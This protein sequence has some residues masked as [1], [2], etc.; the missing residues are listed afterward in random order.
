MSKTTRPKTYDKIVTE[1]IRL[2]NEHGE[3]NITTNHIAAHLGIS[4]GNLYYHFRNK[5]EIVYQIFQRYRYF[6]NQRM[7]IPE[8]QT[9][10]VS[11]LVNYLDTAFEAM[12]RFRFMFCDLYG[13]LNRNPKMQE[14]YKY[15]VDTELKDL[16]HRHFTEFTRLGLVKMQAE[17]T[18]AVTINIWLI[19]KFWFA[20]EQTAHPQAPITEESSRR[21]IRQ[22]LALL[23]PYVQPEFTIPFT[24][25]CERYKDSAI[26]R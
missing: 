9:V 12:W 22:A 13:L 15:F 11:D 20:F 17:D 1:S 14:E 23:K 25:L 24:E 10:T 8:S 7:A 2:F 16:L 21:G 3:R 6:I 26:A 19:I 4:P 18:E 5:E